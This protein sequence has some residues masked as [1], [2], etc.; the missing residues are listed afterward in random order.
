LIIWN[1]TFLHLKGSIFQFQKQSKAR[2]TSTTLK[3][4]IYF[5]AKIICCGYQRF[6]DGH[7]KERN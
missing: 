3:C 4:M 1:G 6:W 7:G 2:A 5:D